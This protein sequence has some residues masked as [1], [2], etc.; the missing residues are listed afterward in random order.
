MKLWP[1]IVLI[2]VLS[3]LAPAYPTAP[4]AAPVK[5]C[6]AT[7]DGGKWCCI[8]GPKVPICWKEPPPVIIPA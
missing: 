8:P 5:S 4:Q 7:P 2:S 3:A 1:K 6:V